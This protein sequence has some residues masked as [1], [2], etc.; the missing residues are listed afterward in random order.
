MCKALKRMSVLAL[1]IAK[2][3]LWR[4]KNFSTVQSKTKDVSLIQ[5]SS[6]EDFSEGT[7]AWLETGAHLSYA[8]VNLLATVLHVSPRICNELQMF[9]YEKSIIEYLSEALAISRDHELSYFQEG[10]R[11]EHVRLIANLAFSNTVVADSIAADVTLL[12]SV[13]SGTK[14]DEENP[15]LVEWSEFAVRNICDSSASAR[16]KIKKLSPAEIDPKTK[17]PKILENQ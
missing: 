11:T 4:T 5:A 14:I 13:L 8:S 1:S 7:D 16:E 15:G 9:L 10:Y 2:H 12:S 6:V 17:A 3:V